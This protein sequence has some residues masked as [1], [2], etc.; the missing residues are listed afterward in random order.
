MEGG[1]TTVQGEDV[2][3]YQRSR[4]VS[5]TRDLKRSTGGNCDE[6][7]R[8]NQKLVVGLLEDWYRS[9]RREVPGETQLSSYAKQILETIAKN[10]SS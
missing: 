10:R 8:G 6:V 4:S 5:V 1:E 7:V 3:Q 2:E 9:R